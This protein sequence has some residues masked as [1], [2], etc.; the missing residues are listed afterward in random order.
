MFETCFLVQMPFIVIT[1][2]RLQLSVLPTSH[3]LPLKERHVPPCAS[4]RTTAC[5]LPGS[6]STGRRTTSSP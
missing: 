4:G 1:T 6:W 2:A 5:G 3:S